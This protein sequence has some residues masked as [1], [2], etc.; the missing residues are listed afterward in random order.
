MATPKSCPLC[1]NVYERLFPYGAI[2]YKNF[3][4]CKLVV[5]RL[6]KFNSFIKKICYFNCLE[7]KRSFFRLFYSLNH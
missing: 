5:F 2:R 3:I 6:Q 7:Q 4:F 1:L